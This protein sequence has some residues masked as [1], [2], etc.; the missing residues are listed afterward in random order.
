M[1]GGEVSALSFNLKFMK[2]QLHPNHIENI[3]AQAAALA[4]VRRVRPARRAGAQ[5]SSRTRLARRRTSGACSLP[6]EVSPYYGCE[7]LKTSRF[8]KSHS[9]H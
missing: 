8:E 7:I 3:S 5:R 2:F 1:V 4:R 9:H 6:G